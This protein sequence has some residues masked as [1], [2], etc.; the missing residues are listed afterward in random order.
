MLNCPSCDYESP[1]SARFCRQCGVTLPTDSDLTE[2]TTRNIGR[3]DPIP[4][5]ATAGSA[6]LPPSIADTFAGNTARYR[7]SSQAAPAYTPPGFVANVM[8]TA[9]LK[10]K[11]RYLKRF[12]W[13]LALFISGG[14]G[15][16]IN[17]ESNRDRVRLSP[18]DRAR[19]ERLRTE[20]ETARTLTG[21]VS[22]RQDRLRDEAQRRLEEV[23]RAREESQRAFER[24]SLTNSD[25]KLLDLNEY[26]YKNATTG[27]Y[28]R[29]PG[30]EVLTQRAKEDFETISQFYQK[31]LGLPFVHR[32]ERN[33]KQSLFQSETIPSVSVLV[34]ESR[35]RSHQTEI[36]VI[37]SPFRF[38]RIQ[39]D[40]EKLE[41][42]KKPAVKPDRKVAQ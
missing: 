35:D 6:P 4:S 2:A 1:S 5:V 31:K 18:A 41:D 21:S 24:G 37:R 26:E 17:Q 16:G 20:D 29:I 39:P 42:E 25:E 36:I 15:A 27:Q 32:N 28:S 33:E 14:I 11:R 12:G 9:S 40:Q 13:V 30:K 22:E 34:R 8:N 38:P 3:Q 23:E 7:A 10:S 19:L